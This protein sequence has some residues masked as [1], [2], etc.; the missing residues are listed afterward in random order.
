MSLNI[1]FQ[2]VNQWICTHGES[3]DVQISKEP[4]NDPW[5]CEPYQ[6][7]DIKGQV[8]EA[9]EEALTPPAL[10][11]IVQPPEEMTAEEST[12]E[13]F[14]D[15]RNIYKSNYEVVDIKDGIPVIEFWGS[16]PE[17]QSPSIHLKEIS[18]SKPEA[19]SKFKQVI[20]D[21]ETKEM[22]NMEIFEVGEY[23]NGKYK[24]TE[25]RLEEIVEN[26]RELKD[27]IKV[28]LKLTHDKVEGAYGWVSNLKKKGKKL[29]ADFKYV[30]KKV[31]DLLVNKKAFARPSIELMPE[32]E[33]KENVLSGVAFLGSELP[34]VDSLDDLLDLYSKEVEKETISLI[35]KPSDKMISLAFDK[36]EEQEISFSKEQEEIKKKKR[37]EK[38]IQRILEEIPSQRS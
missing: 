6:P 9:V 3:G 4:M 31:Y 30:P 14:H 8:K 21:Q 24:A 22:E 29:F 2:T 1:N 10:G 37:Q 26:F 15:F 23:K 36:S 19:F 18:K 5:K 25:K 7:A 33:G 28:P 11:E 27:R 16:P 13:E 17:K 32:F 12:T 38:N 20:N 34:E 35:T